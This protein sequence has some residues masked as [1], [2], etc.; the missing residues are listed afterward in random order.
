MPAPD[1]NHLVNLVL[2]AGHAVYVGQD[3][4]DP[5]QDRNWFLQ[6][7]QRG[8]P[9]FYIGHIRA[10]IDVA[11]R[12]PSSLLVFSG[13]QTR[14]EAGPRSEAQSY[15]NLAEY[16]CWWSIPEVSG[17]ATTEEFARDSFENLLFAI[18]RFKEW[19]GR[20]PQKIRVVS[21][22]FKEERFGLHRDALRFP[23]ERLE[24]VGANQPVDLGGAQKGEAKAI[25]AFKADPYGTGDDLGRKRADRDPFHRVN[26]YSISCP[27]LEGI[28][29]HRGPGLYEGGLPWS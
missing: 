4:L 14:R 22:A 3:F 12:D 11:G 1:S 21:W 28:L 18:C 25:A 20:Y 6:S 2:V 17:R 19:T 23:K 27:E 16:F 26:P 29:R 10:G 7:F 5:E 24:F 9:P 15:W 13:G 8:E